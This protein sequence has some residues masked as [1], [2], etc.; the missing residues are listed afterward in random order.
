MTGDNYSSALEETKE[1]RWPTFEF[2]IN[3]TQHV[4]L[5]LALLDR[6]RNEKIVLHG[7]T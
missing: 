1:P 4:K 5:H 6:E 2:D 7:R 3:D